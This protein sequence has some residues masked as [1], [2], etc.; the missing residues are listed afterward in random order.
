[1][2]DYNKYSKSVIENYQKQLSNLTSIIEQFKSVF[3]VEVSSKF[4]I[5]YH[6]LYNLSKSIKTTS[7]E[8]LNGVNLIDIKST[9]SSLQSI[10]NQAIRYMEILRNYNNNYDQNTPKVLKPNNNK[11]DSK[12][13]TPKPSKKI[14]HSIGRLSDDYSDV[15]KTV[16]RIDDIPKRLNLNNNFNNNKPKIEKIKLE[17]VNNYKPDFIGEDNVIDKPMEDD[18]VLDVLL[19]IEQNIGRL[20]D[21]SIESSKDHHILSEL[22]D[23]NLHLRAFIHLT[24]KQNKEQKD[25]TDMYRR[26]FKSDEEFKKHQKDKD[27]GTLI[28]SLFGS[29]GGGLGNLFS[30]GAMTAL[31]T[32]V[33]GLLGTA[34]M[35]TLLGAIAYDIAKNFVTKK[36]EREHL[37]VGEII[38]NMKNIEVQQL[39]TQ[40]LIRRSEKGFVTYTSDL[41]KS[42]ED[43]V[44]NETILSNVDKKVSEL[45]LLEENL[46][47]IQLKKDKDEK[48]IIEVDKNLEGIENIKKEIAGLVASLDQSLLD[49]LNED[50]K[51]RKLL[52]DISNYDHQEYKKKMHL[53]D[54]I[55]TD[56]FRTP[57]DIQIQPKG[58]ISI[59]NYD[60]DDQTKKEDIINLVRQLVSDGLSSEKISEM[61]EKNIKKDDEGKDIKSLWW[62]IPLLETEKLLLDLSNE[63]ESIKSIEEDRRKDDIS[64]YVHLHKDFVEEI[65]PPFESLAVTVKTWEETLVM[66]NNIFQHSIDSVMKPTDKPTITPKA[67]GGYVNDGLYTTGEN[68]MEMFY[69][70]GNQTKVFNRSDSNLKN[71]IDDELKNITA[72]NISLTEKIVE[73]NKN[74][75]QSISDIMKDTVLKISSDM[76]DIKT[77]EQTDVNERT[78]PII[79]TIQSNYT[80]NQTIANNGANSYNR[81]KDFIPRMT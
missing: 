69:K 7:K 28:G 70:K 73:Q 76:A 53:I 33:I 64:R 78:N 42:D 18:N 37:A 50:E 65:T 80:N 36:D 30:I 66:A 75:N 21:S 31:A 35:V 34:G 6:K 19:R 10:D 79:Q 51:S 55:I 12:E 16:N 47:T 27:K 40:Q 59:T 2:S 13:A 44:K 20:Y 8:L 3:N 32:K 41:F 49:K 58:R 74:I 62:S 54:N 43:R 24:Q 5:I 45:K 14:D 11:T 9:L 15:D 52:F 38:E 61:F 26:S 46:K 23:T 1:M 39:L 4:V 67:D 63:V 17:M 57:G 48:D 22:S 72:N 56:K 81:L 25:F 77:R 68:G 71:I 60:I 29:L